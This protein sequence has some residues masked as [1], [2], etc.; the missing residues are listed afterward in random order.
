VF[1]RQYLFAFESAAHA[2]V[3]VHKLA[4]RLRYVAIFVDGEHVQVI[5]G[6]DDGQ[7][8]AILRLAQSSS[9]TLAAFSD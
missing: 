5:D 9:A 3:F 6:S 8:E 4:L 1:D 2:R 7:R